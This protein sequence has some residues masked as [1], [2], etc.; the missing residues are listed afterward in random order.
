MSTIHFQSLTKCNRFIQSLHLKFS[1]S[2]KKITIHS[3]ANSTFTKILSA[4]LQ[5]PYGWKSEKKKLNNN[6]NN[7]ESHFSSIKYASPKDIP[8]MPTFFAFLFLSS[9]GRLFLPCRSTSTNAEELITAL[10]PLN[11]TT[12]NIFLSEYLFLHVWWCFIRFFF[13][14]YVKDFHSFRYGW[15]HFGSWRILKPRVRLLVFDLNVL[16]T[17]VAI[18]WL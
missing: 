14:Y 18:R 2:L 7:T 16:F 3:K 9:S 1:F 17:C 5:R 10:K 15:V 4:F 6:N 8:P 13:R 11:S 12:K